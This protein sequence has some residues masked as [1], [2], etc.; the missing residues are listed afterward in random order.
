MKIAILYICTG[1]YAS[2]FEAFYKSA[3][4]FLLT[5]A[6]KRY[7]VFTDKADLTKAGNV[8]LIMKECQ[9]F[10][11]DS[12]MRFDMFLSIA[13]RLKAYDYTFFF[14]ANMRFVA[15][16]GQEILPEHLAAVIHPGYYNKPAWR[17]PY[18]RNRQSKAYIPAYQK[19]Y[20]YY[21]GSLNG[22]KTDDF[23]TLAE[24][25]SRNIHDDLTRGI[26]ACYHDESHL[27]HYLRHHPCKPLGPQYAYIEGKRM[28]FEPKIILRD[29][30]KLNPYFNKGRDHSLWGRAKKGAS[31]L[32]DAIRWY[33]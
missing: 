11:M 13:D 19:D 14:N 8:E 17:Y 25:C 16:V 28:P 22:G 29:K 30:T 15:E 24:T 4:S 3:E 32:A 12:L 1:R 6:E 9:G 18:E 33:L 5:E 7:F 31:I 2:F 21:M 27:N 26:I 20:H 23:L 10:P